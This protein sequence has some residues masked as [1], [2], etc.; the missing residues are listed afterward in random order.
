MSYKNMS[1]QKTSKTDG[2]QQLN[3]D[4]AY[5]QAVNHFNAERYNEVDRFCTAIIKA[6]PNHIDAINLLG[7]VAQKFNYL[8]IAVKQFQ[9]AISIKPD[10]AHAHSNLGNVLLEQGK[11]DAAVAS[12]QKAISIKPD[13]ADALY[14]LGTILQKQKKLDGAVAIYQKV[15]SIN[16]N[17]A[18]AHSNLGVIFKKQKKFDEAVTSCQNAITIQPEFAEAHHNLGYILQELGKLE[19]AATSYRNAIAIKPDYSHAH[20]GLIFCIDL[21][22]DENTDN[23]QIERENWAAQHAE[24]LKASW[25]TFINKPEQNRTLRIGYV[26]A[27]FKHHSAAHIFGGMLLNY[28]K[29]KFEVFCYAGNREEDELTEQF[30]QNSTKWISTSSMDDSLLAEAIKTDCIDILVDLSGH[31][32]GNRLLTFANKPAPIQIT[33]WGYPHGTGMDAMDYLF[34]DPY[35]F[36]HS[37]RSKLTE[38]VIDLPCVIHLLDVI[39]FP[40]V[41]DPPACKRGYIT[42]GAFNRLE[43]NNPE[44]Y[45][46]WIEILRRVPTAKLLI[47]SATLDNKIHIKKIESFFQDK[48]ISLHRL[49]FLGSTAPKKHRKTHGEI[50]I[51][52]DPFPHNG[53]MTTL[54]SLKMGVP[55]LT[56]EQKTRCPTSASILHVLGLDSWCAQNDNDYIEK[57]V[58]LANDSQALKTLR[59][60]LRNRFDESVL[61]NSQLYTH[62]VETIYRQL[63]TKW[64]ENHT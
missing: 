32:K 7:V 33:A 2:Q 8:D 27:D 59:H 18:K 57:A 49:I 62:K 20:I 31:T 17:Y 46:L 4:D 5:A 44:V 26:G 45:S 15:V 24:P 52:L 63:W 51:M 47:K 60:Q 11:L 21:I 54:E 42:F 19:E 53:G 16:P 14:N 50:D 6:Y 10:F 9:N 37:E 41:T 30:K 55:I 35:F 43:K 64:C 39:P 40:K 22:S 34:A 36:D 56:H 61:G 28:N 23:Y 58:S 3:V 25:P 38:K 48:G 13:F 12:Y 29:R 1:T